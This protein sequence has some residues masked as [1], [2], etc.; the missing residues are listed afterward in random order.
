MVSEG[1][2][3]TSAEDP[4]TQSVFSSSERR[5]GACGQDVSGPG[6]QDVFL[7]AGLDQPTL[8]VHVLS[9]RWDTCRVS[10]SL[11]GDTPLTPSPREQNVP[12]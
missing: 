12:V 1:M 2:D 4:G 6:A 3:V 10:A 11:Q 5:A 9:K 7:W 8:H